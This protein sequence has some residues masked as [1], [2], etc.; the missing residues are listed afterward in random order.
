MTDFTLE[1]DEIEPERPERHRPV[2]LVATG[3]APTA[4][5]PRATKPPPPPCYTACEG[6]GAAVLTGTTAAGLRLALD[7]HLPTYLVD[8]SAGTPVPVLHVSR[9]YPVHRCHPHEGAR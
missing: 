3:L 7:T 2:R 6:C 8:W 4:E 1:P 5:P 9:A